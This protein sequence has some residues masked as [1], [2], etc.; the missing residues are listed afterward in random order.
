M[1]GYAD[2]FEPVDSLDPQDNQWGM[3]APDPT[4]SYGWYTVVAETDD[5]ERDVLQDAKLQHDRPP[6]AADTL[7]DFR[8]R[9][10]M[11]S[12][13]DNDERADR[14]AQHMC[15]RAESQFDAS[16][17]RTE[18]TYTHHPI[19]LEGEPSTSEYDIAETACS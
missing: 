11:N 6:D 18:V 10:Y 17:D 14:F 13:F 9:R 3:F 15:S 2:T 12:L 16:V 19:E 1:L 7:P 5:G 4:T 8:W